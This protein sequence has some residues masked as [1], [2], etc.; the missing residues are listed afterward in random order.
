MH[1]TYM[2]YKMQIEYIICGAI[3]NSHEQIY[4]AVIGKIIRVHIHL[5][6]NDKK[7]LLMR[8]GA[9]LLKD[10][11]KVRLPLFVFN[12]MSRRYKSI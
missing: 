11:I 10:E 5:C 8:L 9:V 7:R 1:I 3:E 4:C 2:Y 12:K 6:L